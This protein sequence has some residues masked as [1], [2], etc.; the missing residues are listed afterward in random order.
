MSNIIQ[1]LVTQA[2]REVSQ[3]FKDQF[4]EQAAAKLRTELSFIAQVVASN[5]KLQQCTPTSIGNCIKSAAA[6]DL[7]FDPSLNHLYLVP[8]GTVCQLMVGYKGQIYYLAKAGVIVRAVVN[9]VC[10]NDKFRYLDT[11]DGPEWD[12]RKPIEGPRGNIKGAFCF[13]ELPNGGYHGGYF[14]LAEIGLREK[15]SRGGNIWREWRAEMFMKTAARM[16]QKGLPYGPAI[17][18]LDQVDNSH[19]DLD[20]FDMTDERL[21]EIEAAANLCEDVKA[22]GMLYR[23]LPKYE[24]NHY[25]TVKLFETIKEAKEWA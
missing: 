11:E 23:N 2:E 16:A 9:V 1:S 17:A 4:G 22:L 19:F 18:S 14:T 15:K 12:F 20:Q 24:K 3:T 7:S 25:A 10:E 5:T 8:Y 6:L 21:S 13:Y